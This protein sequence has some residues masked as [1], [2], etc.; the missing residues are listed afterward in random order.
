M[1]VGKDFVAAN[2]GAAAAGGSGSSG[3]SAAPTTPGPLPTSVTNEARSADD[4][5]CAGTT[6]GSGG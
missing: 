4:D 2:G 5:I 6:Y 1:I 3:P